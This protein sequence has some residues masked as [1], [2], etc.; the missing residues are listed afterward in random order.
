MDLSVFFSPP[1]AALRQL[2]ERQAAGRLGHHL[3][4][5]P[6]AG[7][8][9]QQADVVMLGVPQLDG[10]LGLARGVR[11]KLFSL[12]LPHEDL[13]LAD[14]GDLLPKDSP[15]AYED[16]LTYVL[17]KLMEAGKTVLLLA[18]SPAVGYSLYQAQV[19]QDRLLNYVNLASHFALEPPEGNPPEQSYNQQIFLHEPNCLFSYTNLG[20]Q[21]YFVTSEALQSLNDLNFTALRYGSLR[22]QCEE[23][24]PYLREADFAVF[25]LSAVRHSDCPGA[26]FPSPGGFSALEA[27]QIA[28]YAGNSARLQSLCL[29]GFDPGQDLHGHSGQLSALMIWYF[30]SA[31]YHRRPLP[32]PEDRSHFRQYNVQLRAA[33]EQIRF[34]YDPFTDHWWMEVPSPEQVGRPHASGKLIACSEA[35][36]Q[37]ARHDEIPERWWKAFRRMGG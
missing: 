18:D 14:L 10:P 4:Q 25:D 34:L 27:C 17:E 20:F 13:K 24:E 11:E 26:S 23:T 7:A 19:P 36:Y 33:I 32:A 22:G 37:T 21:R 12:S 1:D 30:L 31:F 35:D 16:A 8:A 15:E 6:Q 3:R 28:R 2:A 5:Q 9:W 29:S